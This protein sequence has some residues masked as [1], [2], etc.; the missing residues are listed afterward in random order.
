[1]LVEKRHEFQAFF[2]A[3]FFYILILILLH[4]GHA[5][6]WQKCH[7]KH[8][9]QSMLHLKKKKKVTDPKNATK[10]AKTKTVFS[11]LI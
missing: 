11:I 9:T 7:R 5:N 8:H 10:M 2:M 3:F 6:L 4:F 1:M